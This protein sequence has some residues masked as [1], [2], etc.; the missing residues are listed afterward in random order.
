MVAM[1][2]AIAEAHSDR[3]VWWLHGARNG[4]EHPFADE[5]DRLLGSLPHAHR[6]VAYSRPAAGEAPGERFDAVGRLGIETIQSAGVPV[7]A[8]YYLCGPEA[9][10]RTLSAGL[11]AH[12]VPP[13]QINTET[14]GPIAVAAPGIVGAV[15]RA[16]H[17][18]DGPPGDGP[19]VTF[20]R[21]GLTVAWEPSYSTLLDFAEACDV[22]VG[23]GCRTG[24]CHYCETEMLTGEVT[25][26]VDPL[27]PPA[28]GH[29][30]MCC[31]EPRTEVTLE[32]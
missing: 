32:L 9:F 16:P 4:Q 27:E 24:V 28:E 15:A 6:I 23:F 17:Q 2:H 22:P 30:L 13:D 25:Y 26:K 14:F 18:P 7:D 5:V 21:S 29:V 19:V 1:L 31:T 10:M 3:E 8:E 12:G 20:A 11:T